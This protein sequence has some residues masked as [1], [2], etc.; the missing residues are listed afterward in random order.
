VQAISSESETVLRT[1]GVSTLEITAVTV[2]DI[3][4]ATKS[5]EEFSMELFE[6]EMEEEFESGHLI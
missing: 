1:K 4:A 3:E 2:Q 6:R 5:L